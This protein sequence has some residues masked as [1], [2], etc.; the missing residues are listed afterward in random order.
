MVLFSSIKLCCF[1]ILFTSSWINQTYGQDPIFTQFYSNPI[2]LNP[3][4][5][6]RELQEQFTIDLIGDILM[7]K[8]TNFAIR[9]TSVN[10]NPIN[11]F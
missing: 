10:T 3:Q 5:S 2:Y 8:F 11:Y 6:E 7:K 4:L 9:L 1:I